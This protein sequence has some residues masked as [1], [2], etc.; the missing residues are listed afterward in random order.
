MHPP[1]GRGDAGAVV[2]SVR[3][4]V[5]A[6]DPDQPISNV[7]ILDELIA[8]SIGNRRILSLLQSVF[9]ALA[10]I[11]AT[12]GIYGVMSY[13]VRER[14]REFGIRMTFGAN[15]VTLL[16]MILGQGMVLAVGGILIGL[17]GSLA[18]TRVLRSQL[19]K[20]GAYDPATFSLVI[21]MLLG[22]AAMSIFVPANRA[23]RVDPMTTLR[24]E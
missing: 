17:V 11:L 18:L 22:V 21:A 14:F 4:A 15:R 23:S 20:I 6:V 9:G 8:E 24:M 12:V 3:N 13:G 2:P 1:A 19:Y 7:R 5:L 16:Q 10:L